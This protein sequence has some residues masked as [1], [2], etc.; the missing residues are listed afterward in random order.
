MDEL[1]SHAGYKHEDED[2]EV[3]ETGVSSDEYPQDRKDNIV[4]IPFTEAQLLQKGSESY[5][6]LENNSNIRFE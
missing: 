2:E 5:K 1:G 6:V 4:N 3:E